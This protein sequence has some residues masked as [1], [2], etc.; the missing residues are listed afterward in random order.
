MRRVSKNPRDEEVK[1]IEQLQEALHA[2]FSMLDA[3]QQDIPGILQGSV[4][5]KEDEDAFQ[6]DD[7]DDEEAAEHMTAPASEQASASLPFMVPVHQ[8]TPRIPSACEVSEPLHRAT[9]LT[10]RRRQAERHLN[11]LR[12]TIAEK[13]F[14]YSHVLRVA[15]G[16]TIRNRARAAIKRLNDII[17][18]HCRA[19]NKCRS[20]ISRL[21]NDAETSFRY[22]FLSKQDVRAST[23]LL[24]PNIPG[25]STM[26]LSWIWQKELAPAEQSAHALCECVYYAFFLSQSSHYMFSSTCPLVASMGTETAL[27]GRSH[28]CPIRNAVD[29]EVFFVQQGSVG[30][31]KE[32]CPCWS[33]IICRS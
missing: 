17:C 33:G 6:F 10:L 18:F 19:Y 14:Q 1:Q 22:P 8:R 12:E 29:R 5:P 32:E 11:G 4:I 3:L 31:K 15:P 26:R 27:G 21:C 9:E 13:S 7:L 28:P 25:S 2:Q 16:K 24:N 30:G 23:A 20:A